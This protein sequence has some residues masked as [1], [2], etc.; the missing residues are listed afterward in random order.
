MSQTRVSLS[1]KHARPPGEPHLVDVSGSKYFANTLLVQLGSLAP[2][3]R[4]PTFA[5]AHGAAEERAVDGSRWWKSKQPA[6]LKIEPPKVLS[7]D[8]V[9]I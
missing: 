3:V 6:L 2:R 1:P 4:F 7:Y 8:F 5:R 9:V